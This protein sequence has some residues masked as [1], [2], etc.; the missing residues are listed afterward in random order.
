MYSIDA[1][2]VTAPRA[3]IAVSS[4]SAA[5]AAAGVER[6]RPQWTFAEGW[7]GPACMG[8]LMPG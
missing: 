1:A 5:V 3:A 8:A 2:N 7:M 6:D 4:A